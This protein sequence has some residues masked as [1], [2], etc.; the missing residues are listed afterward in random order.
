M[1]RQGRREPR[2]G[3]MGIELPSAHILTEIGGLT[4]IN[5]FQ[6]V[7]SFHRFSE[8]CKSWFWQFLPVWALFLHGSK[9]SELLTLSFLP[10]SLDNFRDM[11]T[12]WWSWH[13]PEPFPPHPCVSCQYWVL[14]PH[15]KIQEDK[16]TTRISSLRERSGGG[17]GWKRRSLTLL[18]MEHF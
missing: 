13:G 10:M 16:E 17:I 15:H 2:E 14:I 18:L 4:W 12:T 1:L 8:P 9:F 7:A 11:A 6:I 3:R 5:T